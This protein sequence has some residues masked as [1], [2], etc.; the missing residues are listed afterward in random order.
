M[1]LLQWSSPILLE[2]RPFKK[3]FRSPSGGVCEREKPILTLQSHHC[4]CKPLHSHSHSTLGTCPTQ[5]GHGTWRERLSHRPSESAAM[6]A[7][8][9][10]PPCP[11]PFLPCRWRHTQLVPISWLALHLH[12]APSSVI[13]ALIISHYQRPCCN[14]F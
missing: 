10:R 13:C 2:R 1:E 7:Q 14:E 11:V 3:D 5:M 6:L 9:L 12:F 8:I 4:Y